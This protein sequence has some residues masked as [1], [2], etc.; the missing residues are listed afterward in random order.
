MLSYSAYTHVLVQCFKKAVTTLGSVERSLEQNMLTQV[1]ELEM[2]KQLWFTRMR[3]S[4]PILVPSPPPPIHFKCWHDFNT[5]VLAI[6]V[7]SFQ[8]SENYSNIYV[9]KKVNWEYFW[10]IGTEPGL[11]RSPSDQTVLCNISVSF[12]LSYSMSRSRLRPQ[13]ADMLLWQALA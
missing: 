7:T 6:F 13:P 8:H 9:P 2:L 5:T 3:N 10:K 11:A 4:P 1:G 12:S